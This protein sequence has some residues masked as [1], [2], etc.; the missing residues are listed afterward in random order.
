MLRFVVVLVASISKMHI[1]SNG[2]KFVDS[3]HLFMFLCFCYFVRAYIEHR[4][5][6]DNL[7][8]FW[9]FFFQ[10]FIEFVTYFFPNFALN[11]RLERLMKFY[12]WFQAFGMERG[13]YCLRPSKKNS[14]FLCIELPELSRLFQHMHY[15]LLMFCVDPIDLTFSFLS[16][17]LV[18]LV[19]DF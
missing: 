2:D 6:I 12:L 9:R 11:K 7:F 18:S 17:N 14:F 16:V 3:V 19:N 13:I 8:Q 15:I 4:T 10:K 1:A 5:K